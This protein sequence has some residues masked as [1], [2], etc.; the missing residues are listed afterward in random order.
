MKNDVFIANNTKVMTEENKQ[1]LM[2]MNQLQP[3]M[4]N[5]QFVVCRYQLMS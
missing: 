3:S 4:H 5:N 2:G 1:D